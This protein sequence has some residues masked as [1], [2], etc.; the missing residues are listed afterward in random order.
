RKT[1]DTPVS[2]RLYLA[3]E[4]SQAEWKLGFT[5]GLG[6]APRLRTIQARN[7]AGLVGEIEQAKERFGLPKEAAVLSCYE[8]G[9][10]GFWLHRYLEANAV[11][12]VVV[13]SA[14]I[15]VN[16]RFRRAKTDRLDV[17]KLLNMLVRYHQGERKVWSV[18]HVPKM[19]EEDQ[20]Q[21]H[22]ELMALKREQTHHINRMKG[23]L[24]SQGI[25]MEVKREFLEEL[26]SVQLW[27]GSS[28]PPGM[29]TLLVREH[30][31]LQL[32]REQIHQVEVTRKEALRT[33]KDP[34]MEQVRRLLQLKGIGINSAWIYVMEF[35]AWRAFHNRRE[36]G[37]LAGLTPTPYASGESAR[38]RGISKAGNRP[39]RAM[40]VEIAWSWLRNQPNSQ[41]SRWY[42]KRFAKGSSRVRRIG[43]VALARKLLIALW[44]YVEEGLVPDGAQ[45]KP[46]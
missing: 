8:A 40:A 27:D 3:L 38:E 30:E 20:R 18:V 15:E 25:V 5:I 17:G 28:I 35:F 33:S 21:L 13:D 7:L 12:N 45:L 4:L 22:R 10:D 43:I 29:Q 14:S 32:V 36:L 6:Q 11:N 39:V 16:R 9:R 42:R 23:L 41:L 24:A 1:N 2:G 44:R 19:G 34:A 31:R 46:A 26:A 37:S